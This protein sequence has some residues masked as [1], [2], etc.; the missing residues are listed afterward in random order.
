MNDTESQ[1]RWSLNESV[2]KSVNLLFHSDGLRVFRICLA[3]TI[4]KSSLTTFVMIGRKNLDFPT[5]LNENVPNIW[6]TMV[7]LGGGTIYDEI[8]KIYLSI[9]VAWRSDKVTKSFLAN[10]GYLSSNECNW[11]SYSESFISGP[12]A[13]IETAKLLNYL[14]CPWFK[15]MCFQN[16]SIG[17]TSYQAL[18]GKHVQFFLLPKETCLF[19]LRDTALLYKQN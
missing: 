13:C 6:S 1:R 9:S 10:R 8:L 7:Y 4:N 2:V 11:S 14:L 12:K 15:C 5:V 17:G 19:D 16:I 3:W 18:F